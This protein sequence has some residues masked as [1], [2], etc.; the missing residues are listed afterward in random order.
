M[1]ERSLLSQMILGLVGQEVA[2]IDKGCG[3]SKEDSGGIPV[4][5]RFGDDYQLP[6]IGN[7]G[8]TQ[9]HRLTSPVQNGCMI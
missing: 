3:N 4:I 8:T 1:D 2:K 6:S 5:I 9:Y 7:A